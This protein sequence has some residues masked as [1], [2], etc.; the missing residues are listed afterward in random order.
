MGEALS[1]RCGGCCR[2][3]EDVGGAGE[4]GVVVAPLGGGATAAGAGAQTGV[5]AVG[6]GAAAGTSVG[7]S[8]M[9]TF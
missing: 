6:A 8:S 9:S 2:A 4:G 5:G 1:G 7:V 3:G